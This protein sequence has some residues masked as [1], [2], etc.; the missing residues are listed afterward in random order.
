M[1]KDMSKLKYTYFSFVIP[2]QSWLE[3]GLQP[4]G[5]LNISS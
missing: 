5:E 4:T 2:W 3:K 1:V